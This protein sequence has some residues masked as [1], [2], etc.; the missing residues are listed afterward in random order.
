M[1]PDNLKQYIIQDQMKKKNI[2]ESDATYFAETLVDGF[3]KVLSGE[4]TM[5]E[6]LRMRYE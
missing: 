3:K 5:E 2:S 1:S 6:V 4:T